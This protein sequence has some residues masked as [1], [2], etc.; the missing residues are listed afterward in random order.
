MP[1][2]AE[3]VTERRRRVRWP[4]VL[5]IVAIVFWFTHEPV[6]VWGLR[7]AVDHFGRRLGVKLEFEQVRLHLFVPI[8]FRGVRFR[9]LN[10]PAS[11]TDVTAELIRL[12]TTTGWR[13]LFGD[14]RVFQDLEVDRLNGTFDFRPEAII[15]QPMPE[16]P[17]DEQRA[18]AAI[19]LRFLP[20]QLEVR[21][22]NAVFLAENQSYTVNGVDGTFYET[23]PGRLSWNYA[24]IEAGTIRQEFDNDTGVTAWK[25]GAMY[26]SD[27]RLRGDVVLRDFVANYVNPGGI[28]LD[29]D[30]G[31]YGGTVRL[32]IE[33]G[34]KNDLVYIDAATAIVNV[35]VEQLSEILAMDGSASGVIRDGR[36]TFRGNPERVVDAE[37]SV[38]LSANDFRWSER[39]WNSLVVGAN[40][41]GRRLYLSTFDLAQAENKISMNGEMAFPENPDDLP[42]SRFLVNLSADVRDLRQLAAL[43]GPEFEEVAG[44]LYL[45]GSLS[46]EKGE[47]DGYLNGEA[48]GIEY[49]GLAPASAKLSVVV[50]GNS[51]EV[52]SGELWSGDDR[53]S[54]RGS[55]DLR[56]PHRYWGE[57]DGAIQDIGLYAPYA[58]EWAANN[59]FTGAADFQWQG[60]G[61]ESA[62]S[63]AFHAKIDNMTT[64]ATPTGL[65]GEF[66]GT[67]S[68]ENIYFSQV[69]LSHGML[70][71][72]TRVTIAASGL[73]LSDI[74][75]KRRDVE[76]LSGEAF[77]PLNVFA[78]AAG[79]TLAT[80]LDLKKPVYAN[81]HSS[82]LSVADL[83]QMVGQ[84][85]AV[86]GRVRLG[87]TASGTLPELQLSGS[88]TARDLSAE[89]EDFSIP[90]TNIDVDLDSR[91]GRVVANG[92]VKMSGF[93]PMT[94]TAGMPFAFEETSDG[95]VR[96]FKPD[97]PIEAKLT[98]PS[99]SV[100]VFRPWL[101]K[102]R[103]MQGTVAGAL[104]VAGT[105]NAPDI[106]GEM[107]VRGG[108][109]EIDVN[110]PRLTAINGRLTF[111]DS[112]LTC[113][114]LRG[115]VGAGPFEITGW[116][117]FSNPAEPQI[118]LHLKG[119]KI[120]LARD[121]GLRL[122]ADMNL[123]LQGRGSSGELSGSVLLVD[124]RIFR[125]LEVTPLLVPNPENTAGFT[126]PSFAG[127]VPPPFA[128]WKLNIAVR[129]GMPF[130][131]IG[132]LA[133]GEISPELTI[134]GTLGAPFAAGTV[135]LKDL[136]AY[137]PASTLLIPNGRIYFT[138]ERPF[139]P[140]MDVRAR[141][142][143]S[144]YNVQMYAYGALS[145]ANLALR[146]DPPL[147]QEDL[148]ALLTTG[149]VPAGLTGTGFGEAAVGQGGVILLRSIARQLEPMGIDLNDAVNRLTVN[150]VPPRDPSQTSALESRL[151]LTDHFSLTTGRDGFGFYNAGVQYTIKL[152]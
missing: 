5:A 22:S 142:E 63:G 132:N 129:N 121:P 64:A 122:R 60:D 16:L 134:S 35:P 71:L 9:V 109:I 72:D 123:D 2:N 81:L 47:I 114:S 115:E 127:L 30:I 19:V 137:L 49:M 151:K 54:A 133:T 46:G 131:L 85:A 56:G 88:F 117:E 15:P 147:S 37:V 18:L 42:S 148:I 51:L 136:Q 50:N 4:W 90:A 36:L 130:L 92:E 25:N 146:S 89:V 82:E 120:L 62:H 57:I 58:G 48:S 112:R 78:L 53:V 99:A 91:D 70:G 44:R 77:V 40:Y 31:A 150:V 17:P 69:R 84:E 93:Q 27:F 24:L 13:M 95:G 39:G 79:G 103:R 94:L 110:T 6:L 74:Q 33:F 107:T 1:E 106:D 41:I 143:V 144:G 61:T 119:S 11:R 125:R 124:G 38:R 65:T 111:K 21:S 59:V 7:Q 116:A 152:R 97:A 55:I 45:H 128:D 43:A 86:S 138:R 140:I 113:E 26:V 29:A 105:L 14:G 75:L 80:A 141:A 118:Q 67:Y 73:N 126:V 96:L 101:P 68:P 149:I 145:Q 98:F 104:N 3:P 139:M 23:K 52:R 87:L 76:I 12:K 100:E 83:S 66:A 34:A 108:D 135:N 10:P 8:E 20:L 32:T 28:S 102:A